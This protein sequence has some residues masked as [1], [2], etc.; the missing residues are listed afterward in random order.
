MHDVALLHVPLS[1]RGSVGGLG[2]GGLSCPQRQVEVAVVAAEP[3]NEHL[4]F[5]FG[6]RIAARVRWVLGEGW[7]AIVFVPVEPAMIGIANELCQPF[8]RTV[9]GQVR[10]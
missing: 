3:A 6:Q 10:G 5:V 9:T 1:F 2:M 7:H 8:R 4:K